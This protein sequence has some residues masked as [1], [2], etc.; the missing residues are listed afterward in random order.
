MSKSVGGSTTTEAWD[1][2]G[3]LPLMLEDKNSSTTTDYVFGP[4][5]LPLEQ[6]VGSTTL[7]YGH[8][9]LGSTRVVTGGSGTVQAG[10]VYDPYGN[11]VSSTGS[12][13]NQPFRFAGQYQDSESGLY[14]LRA[15]YYDPTTTQFLARDPAVATT[16]SPYGYVA[17]NPLNAA[18]PSGVHVACGGADNAGGGSASHSGIDSCANDLW[19]PAPHLNDPCDYSLVAPN[20]SQLSAGDVVTAGLIVGCPEAGATRLAAAAILGLIGL[21]VIKAT[22]D[23]S[24][25][26]GEL[27]GP[28]PLGPPV[29]PTPAPTPTAT[30]LPTATPRPIYGPFLP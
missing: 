7:W 14:Y 10:Y 24:H 23:P 13:S 21:I 26:R 1:L 22:G 30:P 6:I 28:Y 20:C 19:N 12:L 16:R 2:A 17:G 8:D 29:P 5:G 9:H 3:G 4:G 11:L 27:P 25:G 18:D 15:R